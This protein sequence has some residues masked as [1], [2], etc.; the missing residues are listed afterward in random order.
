MW[1]DHANT[2]ARRM[3]PANPVNVTAERSRPLARDLSRSG[4]KTARLCHVKTQ[5]QNKARKT[6]P[7]R[8]SQ[9]V[10]ETSDALDL[11]PDV[12]KLRSAKQVAASLKR[13]AESS[14]RRK[15]TA[16]QSAMSM[17]NFYMNRA[18]HNLPDSRKRVLEN[19]K[20]E[21]RRLFGKEQAA[22]G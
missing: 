7:N 20:T 6:T 19:A 17:L 18:G 1:T 10:T 12:F 14:K 16:Y 4:G 8:W 3:N 15:G 5:G 21:L 13:S 22:G 2:V 11:E 9:H